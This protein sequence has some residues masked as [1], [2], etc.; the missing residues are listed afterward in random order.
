MSSKKS[1]SKNQQNSQRLVSGEFEPLDRENFDTMMDTPNA[2]RFQSAS[3]A[4]DRSGRKQKK[5]KD[6]VKGSQQAACC[7]EGG[8][9]GGLIV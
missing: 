7:A 6:K 4:S 8:G 3:F 9:P 2:L 5:K 1:I